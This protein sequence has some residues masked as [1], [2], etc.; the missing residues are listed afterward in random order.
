M[1]QQKPGAIPLSAAQ[2]ALCESALDVVHRCARVV[3]RSSSASVEDLES[4]GNEALIL[5]AV[6][7]DP[8]LGVPFAGF[9]WTRIRG[10]M[11]RYVYGEARVPDRLRRT[12]MIGRSEEEPFA[13]EVSPGDACVEA[14]RARAAEVLLVLGNAEADGDPLEV[15]DWHAFVRQTMTRLLQQLTPEEQRLVRAFYVNGL[16]IDQVAEEL[17]MNR[18]MVRRMHDKVK[19]RLFA[20]FTA[21]G[22]HHG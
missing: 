15:A 11:L 21:A 19:A 6:R 8:S 14:A 1:R 2:R 10:A 18:A 5:A 22:V 9:A 3:A 12:L 16:T 13:L 7:F 4:V 20:G 17:R